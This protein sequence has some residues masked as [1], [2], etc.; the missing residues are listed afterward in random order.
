M[1][2]DRR[3]YASHGLIRRETRMTRKLL[4]AFLIAA[5]IGVALGFAAAAFLPPMLA[6]GA[7]DMFLAFIILGVLGIVIALRPSQRALSKQIS[8]FTAAFAV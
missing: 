6:A 7:F 3:Y 5:P 4:I 1:R 2:F 8:T